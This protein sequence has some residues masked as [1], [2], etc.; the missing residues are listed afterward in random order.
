MI[1]N[2]VSINL[3][4]V[5]MDDIQAAFNKYSKENGLDSTPT[6][7]QV[8]LATSV[9]GNG[10]SK[11]N[12]NRLSFFVNLGMSFGTHNEA[13]PDDILG[14][15]K[16]MYEVRVLVDDYSEDLN[17]KGN[18]EKLVPHEELLNIVEPYFRELI[19][20]LIDCTE[21]SL[22]TIPYHFWENQ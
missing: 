19:A 16:T 20:S 18:I 10:V 11:K 2:I 9:R 12:A 14:T 4:S 22:A 15:I 7:I 3:R 1:K 13:E 8:K 5:N 21:L 17:K 6:E